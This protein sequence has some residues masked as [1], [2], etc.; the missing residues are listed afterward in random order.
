MPK[1]V[2]KASAETPQSRHGPGPQGSC[3]SSRPTPAER[4]GGDRRGGVERVP[5]ALPQPRAPEKPRQLTFYLKLGE[6]PPAPRDSREVWCRGPRV[7]PATVLGRTSGASQRAACLGHRNPA[8]LRVGSRRA[9]PSR[10]RRSYLG[11]SPLLRLERRRGRGVTRPF[12]VQ[13]RR[14]GGGRG[15]IRS[16]AAERRRSFHPTLSNPSGPRVSD[17]TLDG[18]PLSRRHAFLTGLVSAGA[19]APAPT[20]HFQ[21]PPVRRRRT[22]LPTAQENST[23]AR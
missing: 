6:T 18:G 20:F 23:R 13:G 4:R 14:G 12:Q 19:K 11:P 21:L 5:P 15:R 3:A 1:V 22:G 16:L 17:S 9:G 10:V 2:R 7:R 8:V